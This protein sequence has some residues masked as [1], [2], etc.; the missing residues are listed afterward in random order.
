MV[1]FLAVR[2]EEEEGFKERQDN[3]CSTRIA[4]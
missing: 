4:G 3:L 1:Y 2:G